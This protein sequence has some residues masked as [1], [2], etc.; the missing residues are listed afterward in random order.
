MR[1]DAW[2]TEIGAFSAARSAAGHSAGT[3][4][5][6]RHYLVRLCQAMRRGPWSTTTDDLARWLAGQTWKRETRRSAIAALRA[7]WAWGVR[8]GRTADDPTTGLERVRESPPCPRPAPEDVVAESLSRAPETV[9]LMIRLAAELGLRRA[10]V[11]RV[12]GD[13]LERDLLGWTLR[14]HGK[15]GKVRV[16][17]VPDDLAVTLRVRCGGGFAFPGRI[18]GH[19]SPGR[20]GELVGDALPPGVTMHALRH[21]FATRAYAH[22]RD[23]LTVQGLLGHASPATTQ[24]YVLPPASAARATVLAVARAA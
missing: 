18:E 22:D 19:L 11:A 8:T 3:V 6:Q 5:L 2:V 14:V 4:R 23:L 16:V 21:R 15:G 7:F 10:E 20:V 17:P 13:D 24:R 9:R 12:H 1:V